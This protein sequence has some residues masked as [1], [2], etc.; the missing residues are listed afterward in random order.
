MAQ[1]AQARREV[2]SPQKPQVGTSKSS[3]AGQFDLDCRR[4]YTCRYAMSRIV[5]SDPVLPKPDREPPSMKLF[6]F[7][8]HIGQYDTET[9]TEEKVKADEFGRADSKKFFNT[10]LINMHNRKDG[11][12]SRNSTDI[13]K[14][15]KCRTPGE[16][17]NKYFTPIG[18]GRGRVKG[19]KSGYQRQTT[20]MPVKDTREHMGRL[21]NEESGLEYLQGY[22]YVLRGSFLTNGL[23]LK[24]NAINTCIIAKHKYSAAG[25][26]HKPDIILMHDP[27]E[28]YDSYLT[29][30]R[31]VFPDKNTVERVFKFKK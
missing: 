21:R 25:S 4:N 12:A 7:K 19:S 2:L 26:R 16:I 31:N 15:M 30:V 8:E 27:R 22:R 3:T 18:L 9:D 1:N 5:C 17:L 6:H 13:S 10:L 11:L 20:T 14:F 29:E 28:G 24:L 23:Q